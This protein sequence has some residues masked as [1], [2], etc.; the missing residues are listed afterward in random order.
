MT[1]ALLSDIHGN[2]QALQSCLADAHSRGASRYVFLGDLVGYGADP[3]GVVDIVRD[4]VARGAVAVRGNHD[5][6]IHGSAAYMNESAMRAIE[7]SREVLSDEQATFLKNLPMIAREQGLCFVHASARAPEHYHYID[8][9]SAAGACAEAAEATHTFCG[10]VHEQQLYFMAQPGRMTLFTPT[11][12][13]AVPVPARRR[14][15]AIVGSVGQPRDRN[16]KAAY[17]LFDPVRATITFCR[18]AY[19][20]G[21]AAMRIRAA[22]LPESLAYRVEHG[23]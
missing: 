6:A 17:T 4:H 12:G 21:T 9:P 19:D 18:V 20:H 15:V 5:D 2:L 11:P 3:H 1:I 14:W 7:Y 23:Y 8:S 13:I 10:H 16:P 22:G